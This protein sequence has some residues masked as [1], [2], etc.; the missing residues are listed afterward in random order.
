MK[1]L[2]V[3]LVAIFGSVLSHGAV[4]CDAKTGERQQHVHLSWNGKSVADWVVGSEAPKS[5]ELPNGVKLGVSVTDAPSSKYEGRKS[6]PTASPHT[7]EL[8]KLQLYDMSQNPPLELSHTWAGANSIQGFGA[9]GGADRVIEFG[10]PG[11]EM[12]LLKPVCI[13]SV[14]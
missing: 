14:E 9:A 7:P 3:G 6:D 4:A 5:V 1:Y 2:A 12:I 11:I 13:A 10:T 8:V